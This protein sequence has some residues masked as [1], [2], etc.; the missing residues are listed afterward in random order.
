MDQSLKTRLESAL[1]QW[2]AHKAG[3][4]PVEEIT[5]QPQFR[6]LCEANA[7]GMY[8]RNWMCPPCVG[9]VEEL[10]AQ[11]R[12][13]RWALVYQT[14]DR[15]EDSFDF[16]GMVEAARRMSRLAQTV[17][18]QLELPDPSPLYLAAGACGICP[19]CAKTEDKPCRFPQLA[20]SS[21]EAYGIDVSQLASLAGMNYTSGPDT[22]T[23]FAAVLF[24][25]S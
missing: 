11:A 17:R 10:I 16:E 3:L 21:L 5:F 20:L 7:C 19:V 8:G 12:G 18:A 13:Y 9:P 2:G 22:V 1:I 25:R 23:Y 24:G 14:V 15:L 6:K 4:V